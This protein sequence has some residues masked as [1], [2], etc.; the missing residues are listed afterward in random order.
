MPYVYIPIVPHT[1]QSDNHPYTRLASRPSVQVV[2]YGHLGD[3]NL[4]LNIAIPRGE[5]D[6]TE[7]I[8]AVLPWVMAHKG[9]VSAEHG[10][11]QLKAKYLPMTKS[12]AVYQLMVAQKRLL[13]PHSILNPFKY[14]GGMA[15][16]QEG[17]A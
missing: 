17:K 3:S 14:Y 4:H 7:A 12:P 1:H 6:P 10:L 11:G 13:D 15:Q 8:D 9:S 16:Q 5:P 2:G